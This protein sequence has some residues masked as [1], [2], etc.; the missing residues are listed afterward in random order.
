MCWPR[1][2]PDGTEFIGWYEYEVNGK[3]ERIE[4]EDMIH[5]K[6]GVDPRDERRGFSDLKTAVREVCG[7]NECDT[8]TSAIMRNMGIP[9]VVIS[10]SDPDAA[11]SP[12]EIPILQD[13]FRE[14]FT[15]EG[16][17]SALFAPRL[18]KVEKLSFSPEELALD[19]IPSRLEDRVC[20][21][22]GLSPMV[23]HLTAGAQSKTYANYGESRRAA[24]EDCLIP[25][26]KAWAECLTNQ[27]LI[28]EYGDATRCRWDYSGCQCLAEN[29]TEVAERVGKQY[30]VYQ[31]ITRAEARE[32]QGLDW[33]EEDEIYFSEASLRTID[34]EDI[35]PEEDR[36][37]GPNELAEGSAK[38]TV[39][40]GEAKPDAKAPK[41]VDE[42]KRSDNRAVLMRALDAVEKMLAGRKAG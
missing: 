12:E 7:L 1:W 25:F 24:Y 40:G 6:M 4:V 38:T 15:S 16:R 20:A 10:T 28:P 34:E 30:Q 8:Y 14:M 18:M 37:G 23:V 2:N 11:F 41:A 32:M 13:Q 33:T 39:K 21:V 19:K 9:G 36:P 42:P 31:T 29:E 22:L 35:I 17:G 26:Q 5:F 3:L 27:L